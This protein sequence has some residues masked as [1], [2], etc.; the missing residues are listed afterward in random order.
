MQLRQRISLAISAVLLVA[1]ASLQPVRA[2]EQEPPLPAA[3]VAPA[4]PELNSRVIVR[5]KPAKIKRKHHKKPRRH[6]H[7]SRIVRLAARPLSAA[8]HWIIQHESAGKVWADNPTS[9]AFGIGQLLWSNRVHYGRIL[10]VS[11]RTTSYKAQLA[12]FRLY[13][14]DRYRTATAAMR[15]RMRHGWY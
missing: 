2:P 10:H 15:F 12:M 14:R 5:H 7:R 4:Q 11:P 1:A 8:E 6:V 3:F 9:S 13:V